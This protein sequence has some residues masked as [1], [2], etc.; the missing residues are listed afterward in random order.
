MKKYISRKIIVIITISFV[1][2]IAASFSFR[3][4][5]VTPPAPVRG[6]CPVTATEFNSW[7]N[8][9]SVTLNGIVKPFVSNDFPEPSDSPSDCEFFQWSEQTF[10]WLTSPV[11]QRGNTGM[12]LSNKITERIFESPAFYDVSPPDAD[13]NRTFIPHES[14]KI[15]VSGVREGKVGPN[16][17]PVTFEKKTGRLLEIEKTTVSAKGLPLII[18]KD[19]EQTEVSRITL[20]NAGKP[21]FMDKNSKV[22][23]NPRPLTRKRQNA[24]SIVHKFMI[25]NKYVFVDA[26]GNN[27]EVEE[28]QAD[29]GVLMSQNNSL[30]YYSISVNQLYALTLTGLANDALKNPYGDNYNNSNL[31]VFLSS[32]LPY[33]I[34]YGAAHGITIR[35]PEAATIEIKCSWVEAASL[36]DA[37]KYIKMKAVIPSYFKSPG[38]WIPQGQKTVE[39]AMVGMHIV[40]RVAWW[41]DMLWA[42]FE[43]V[44]NTPNAAYNYYSSSAKAVATGRAITVPQNTSGQWTFCSDGSTGPFNAS[45]MQTEGNKIVANS[46]STIGPSNIIRWKP[47]GTGGNDAGTNTDLKTLNSSVMNMLVDG[48]VR[49]NYIQIG[50]TWREKEENSP[51][52]GSTRLANTTME[53]FMQGTNNSVTNGT[54]CFSCH[55]ANGE[56]KKAYSHIY[57]SIKPLF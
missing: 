44:N 52:K 50:T 18:N 9:G 4:S 23:Q 14:G 56:D 43:H 19:G 41:P 49:K 21:V 5:P 27:I 30:V 26:N 36:P 3:S 12:P 6:G 55:A 38:Q 54:T 57:Y 47:W 48:D 33:L 37:G 13:G 39:L 15:R 40:G 51:Q 11:L 20:D 32:A 16:H 7:F 1:V 46:G 17:L 28:T 24:E 25:D 31:N 53:T 45:R 10:L 42:T 29:G 22:I 35:Y 2:V 34:E 8:S